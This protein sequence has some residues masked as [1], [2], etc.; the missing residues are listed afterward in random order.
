MKRRGYNRVKIDWNDPKQRNA[1]H[2]EKA[3]LYRASGDG[4]IYPL[5]FGIL[6]GRAWRTL[7]QNFLKQ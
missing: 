6:I 1:Y 2:A 7:A 5:I 4:P 3:R